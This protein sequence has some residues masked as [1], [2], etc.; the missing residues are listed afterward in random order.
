[1][2]LLDGDEVKIKCL[3]YKSSLLDA[4]KYLLINIHLALIGLIG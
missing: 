2:V 3:A 1:M 4:V